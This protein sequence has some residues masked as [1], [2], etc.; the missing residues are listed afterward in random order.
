MESITETCVVP[1]SKSEVFEF[2]SRIENMPKWS[3][4]FVKEIFQ[5]G[6]KFKAKTPLGIMSIRFDVDR[7]A[8][9]I[10]IYAGPTEEQMTA[11][12]LRVIDFSPL[13]TGVMFTFFK[14]TDVPDDLWKIFRVWIKKEVGNINKRFSD[15]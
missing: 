9:T 6:G 14:Y 11:G 13:S 7:N 10:D 5:E 12:F 3:T 4:E 15:S 8:G 2:L 1:K